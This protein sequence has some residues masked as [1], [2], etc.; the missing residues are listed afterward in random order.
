[1]TIEE[2]YPC[3][4]CDKTYLN[5][6]TIISHCAR[7]HF[8]ELD[9]AEAVWGNVCP[10]CGGYF[11]GLPQHSSRAHGRQI[12]LLFADARRD[13]D[14]HGVLGDRLSHFGYLFVQWL[15]RRMKELAP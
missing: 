13:R 2:R 7:D 6:D 9:S 3:P 15:D 12:S 1:M 14:P 11:S 8:P 10:K 5:A 4:Y